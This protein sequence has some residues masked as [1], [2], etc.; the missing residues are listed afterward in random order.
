M[1]ELATEKKVFNARYGKQSGAALLAFMLAFIVG[2][3]FFL[4]KDINANISQTSYRAATSFSALEEAKSAL[5]SYAVRYPEQNNGNSKGP[6]WLPCPS[7][8]FDETDA[9]Y[10]ESRANCGTSTNTNTGLLPWKT[11]GISE[12]VDSEGENIWY[13]LS[14]D[15]RNMLPSTTKI[16]SE[17]AGQIS[18]DG[19]DDIVAVVIAPGRSLDDYNQNRPSADPLDYLEGENA[20]AGDNTF[21][22]T[23][24]A[25][26]NDILVTITRNELMQ[27]VEKRVLGEVRNVLERYYD[28]YGKYPWLS[29]YSNP[30]SGEEIS[31]SATGGSATQLVD[32]GQDFSLMGLAEGD[33]VVNV[34]DGSH[35]RIEEV[36]NATT[37]RINNL[38]YGTDNDFGAGDNYIIPRFNGRE[39]S[40]RGHI[41]YLTASEYFSSSFGIDW[42]LLVGSTVTVDSAVTPARH[43]AGMTSSIKNSHGTVS[44]DL[45][46]DELSGSCAWSTEDVV[47][48]KGS[49]TDFY[50]LSSSVTGNKGA[51]DIRGA[52]IQQVVDCNVDFSD[53]GV[54]AG[55]LIIN[56]SDTPATAIES[57]AEAGSLNTTLVDTTQ[58][59]ITSGIEP[60]TFLVN[61]LTDET[62]GIVQTVNATELA[63]L[64]LPGNTIL[65]DV[66]DEYSIKEIRIGMVYG[67][68]STTTDCPYEGSPSAVSTTVDML[69]VGSTNLASPVSFDYNTGTGVGD[70]YRVIMAADEVTDNAGA[71]TNGAAFIVYDNDIADF[72]AEGVQVGDVVKNTWFN[73][74]GTVTALGV[75]GGGAWF[76]YTA[77]QGGSYT[78]IFPTEGYAIYHTHVNKRE[79][80]FEFQFTGD[81]DIPT[82]SADGS[83]RRSVCLG[84]GADCS[85]ETPTSVRLTTNLLNPTV[86]IKDYHLDN[87]Q[88]GEAEIL[89]PDSIGGGLRVTG[90]QY[91]YTENPDGEYAQDKLPTWFTENNWHHLI[92]AAYSEG[93]AP[94][95][96][97]ACVSGTNCLQLNLPNGNNDAVQSV[98]IAAG[99]EINDAAVPLVQNRANGGLGEYFESDNVVV[100]DIFLQNGNQAGYNDQTLVL[101]PSPF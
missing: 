16:N 97:A 82:S 9:Q 58:N 68:T 61:N 101:R 28:T 76:T 4:L 63:I 25:D 87:S 64:P 34:S 42:Q 29:P 47:D 24:A 21:S 35:G 23:P 8:I 2:G 49:T 62:E 26:S 86:V 96:T 93:D 59:F 37:L 85:A 57:T 83:K 69:Q 81:V 15:Y 18:V 91:D 75:D 92:Y 10:G 52:T 17:T 100:D 43:Q 98:V 39:Q 50:F 80:D 99:Y 48:C 13:A 6:G 94:G 36:V 70:S 22:Y 74:V 31:G 45:A 33:L 3:T 67:V 5:I 1:R 73:G 53:A 54:Q 40:R 77:L 60:R 12:L 65:F 78:D 27:A 89:I 30:R 84:Y 20:T 90:I 32:S 11:L 71:G 72:A 44:N 56:Y 55:D 38:K 46:V 14:D 7:V 88:L 19:E 95:A 66:G 51:T 41:P 79:Y